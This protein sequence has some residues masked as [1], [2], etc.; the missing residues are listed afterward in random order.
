MNTTASSVIAGEL[1]FDIHGR[2]GLR[3]DA[4]APAA[5]QLSTMFAGFAV[6]YEVPP[7]VVVD[8]RLQVLHGA[9]HLENELRYTDRA[10]DILHGGVQVERAGGRTVV[11]GRGE[12]L[13]TVLPLVDLAMVGRGAGMIHAATVAYRGRAVALPAAGGTGKTSTIAKLMKRPGFSFMGDDW[14]FLGDDG[15]LLS[16]EKPMFIKPHHRPIYPHLFTGARKPLVPVAL[17]RPVGRVTTVVH[18]YIARRPRL[19]DI[20]RRWSPEHR[21]V[22]VSDA[23]PGVEVTRSAPLMA[24]VFVERY[25]GAKTRLEERSTTWMVDRMIGNFHVE[26]PTFSREVL[27]ALSASSLASHTAFFEDKA[28]ALEKGLGGSPCYVLQVPGTYS[29]D[30][31]SDEIVTT[32]GD[33][34]GGP[35]DG[36]EQ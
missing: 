22:R 23:L 35:V 6:D 33:L 10:V 3:V 13:T 36:G 2:L 14:A 16:F 28:T 7:D 20:S 12:L 24:S 8:G 31:A 27:T 17:S 5:A 34:L 11:H 26:M 30:I 4:Q 18:P 32:L 19:A 1:H 9:S 21:I 29:P 25:D 15:E